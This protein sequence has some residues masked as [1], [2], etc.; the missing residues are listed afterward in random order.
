[1]WKICHAKSTPRVR[2]LELIVIIAASIFEADTQLFVGHRTFLPF[3]ADGS[4]PSRRL[5]NHEHAVFFAAFVELLVFHFHSTD[6]AGVEGQFH[7]FVEVMAAVGLATALLGVGFPRSFAVSLVRSAGI[8]FQGLRLVVIG[9]MWIPSLVPKG[10][11]LVREHHRDAVRCENDDSLHRAKALVNLQFGWCMSLVALFVVALYLYV[12]K[13]YP[14]DEDD[15]G[16]K[17]HKCGPACSGD[18]VHELM[19][20]EVEV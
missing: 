2:Y 5:P 14:S 20:L 12:C 11:S 7:L 17:M 16:L 4:I 9:V 10:C 13:R 6:H 18:D 19:P 8:A 1:M 3:D 15:D